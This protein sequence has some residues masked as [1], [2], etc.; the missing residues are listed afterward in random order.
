MQEKM[1]SEGQA[2]V[3]VDIV[4][5]TYPNDR[6]HSDHWLEPLSVDEK[7]RAF[8]YRFERDRTCF[9]AG[10]YLL[11]RTLAVYLSEPAEGL[12]FVSNAY[13]KACIE[14]DEGVEFSLTNA[15]GLVAVAVGRGCGHVGIDCE[16]ADLIL[17]DAA[18]ETFCTF[19]ELSWIAQLSSDE[20]RRAGLT[21]WT[22][23]ESYLKAIGLGLNEDPQNIAISWDGDIPRIAH[24]GERDPRWHHRLF[25]GS[26]RHI[27]ALSVYAELG[28]P[29][30]R[31]SDFQDGAAISE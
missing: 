23:K 20:R 11:R 14:G 12:R 9:I 25:N 16:P 18:L 15:D 22:L 10:R 26:G 2:R 4:R 5:W 13:G 7:E 17:E 3:S 8:S 19:D 28:T 29:T 24:K 31:L 27:I 30:F 21:L 1:S 6:L